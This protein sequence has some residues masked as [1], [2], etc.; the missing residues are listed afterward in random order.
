MIFLGTGQFFYFLYFFWVSGNAFDWQD[1]TKKE[2]TSTKELTFLGFIFKLDCLSLLNTGFY[3]VQH[4]INSRGKNA[5]VIE[6]QQKG[7]KLLILQ[8]LFHLVTETR[9]HIW[10]SEWHLSKL[11]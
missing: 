4:I 8:A 2:Y 3:L 11:V 5:D 7:D 10:E 9:A 1:M 6:V